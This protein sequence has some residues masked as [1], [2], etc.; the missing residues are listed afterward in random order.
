MANKRIKDLATAI[1][2]FRTGD[3]IAVDGTNGTAK[4]AKNNLLKETAKSALS[5]NAIPANFPSSL[6]YVDEV[7][8]YYDDSGTL[9]ESYNPRFLA[10]KYIVSGDAGF[11]IRANMFGA[12]AV[13]EFDEDDNFIKSH[14]IGSDPY[15]RIDFITD[16][17]C[18]YL[19]VST[20]TNVSSY[21]GVF[22]N[23]EVQLKKNLEVLN[24]AFVADDVLGSENGYY[25]DSAI[26]VPSTS[27]LTL[28]FPVE[29][30]TQYSWVGDI[31]GGMCAVE[32]TSTGLMIALHENPSA[33]N[34]IK[35]VSITTS[36]N[37]SS[38]KVTSRIT[39]SFTRPWLLKLA[40]NTTSEEP[41]RPTLV[42]EGA[43]YYTESGGVTVND[44]FMFRKYAVNGSR[45]LK[46]VGYFFG[47]IRICEF[48]KNG[49]FICSHH[50]NGTYTSIEFVTR[51]DCAYV[52]IAIRL[53][54]G[55]AADLFD[56][57]T[58][59]AP[60]PRT[61]YGVEGVQKNIYADRFGIQPYGNV[62]IVPVPSEDNSSYTRFHNRLEFNVA[63]H[64][65]FSINVWPSVDGE[66]LFGDDATP[67]SSVTVKFK[68]KKNPASAKNLLWVGDSIS[69]YQN[70]AKYAKEIF[71]GIALGVAPTFV[72]T[73]HTSGTPDESYGGRN[74]YWLLR[75]NDSPFRYNDAVDFAHYN[76]VV[77]VSKIDLCVM[78]MGFNDASRLTLSY[79]NTLAEYKI[80]Y[81]EFIEK[82]TVAN[83][84]IKIVWVLCPFGSKYEKNRNACGHNKGVVMLRNLVMELSYEYS[85][86]VVSDA[87][88]CIDS[89]NGYPLTKAPIAS[90]YSSLDRTQEF[91]SDS[92]H[93]TALGC[94]EW[95]QNVVGAIIEAFGL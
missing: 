38:L 73:Q 23:D 53:Q 58:N 16:V 37:T 94:K 74:T 5:E 12:M 30:N 72:G 11:T 56:L 10:R 60:F 46:A 49:V 51:H 55:V 87:F 75:D 43:G 9:T 64:S 44:S 15:D 66:S 3:Y 27:M 42:D 4:M 48:D 28:E 14:W 52:G 8:G 20:D 32:L 69:D 67:S 24:Y 85:N 76:S 47:T 26:F 2:S 54:R 83:P 61:M 33:P 80:L 21:T 89:V 86:V 78:A 7:Q 18:S 13:C 95:G 31:F 29:P 40:K 92:T 70:T 77:G 71:D 22:A 1:T 62:Y 17:R 91:C 90:V 35:E 19:W 84:G 59:K 88:Y 25:N 41:I 81:K 45:Y 34:E 36:E 6:P 68:E 57:G 79:V 82:I 65:D 39:G 50:K 93:P 63:S